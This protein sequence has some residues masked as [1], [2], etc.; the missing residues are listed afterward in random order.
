MNAICLVIDRLH[1]GY[2]GA[3]GN[4]WI[5]T[6]AVDR[7]ASQS[8]L[9]DQA[10]L[11]SPDLNKIYRSYWQ[12]CHALCAQGS[13]GERPSL[14]ACLR[15]SGVST[16]L[17]TD[18]PLVARHALAADFDS[19]VEIDPPWQSRVA[20][21]IE[22]THF[23]G[24]FLQIIDYLQSARE[25][26]MLW[27]HLAGLGST[28]DAPLS[29]RQAYQDG[30]DP[31]P[32]HRAEVPERIL[33]KNYDPDEL[34]G[35]TQCY[36]GQVSLLDTCLEAFLDFL[37][38][39]TVRE[40]LLLAVTSSRGFPLGEHG[41]I[42]PCDEALY[43]ELVQVP[44]LLRFPDGLG[45]AARSQTLV[46]P[47]DLWAT[48][49]QW[50]QIKAAQ[51]SPTA[52]SLIPVVREDVAAVRDRM[53]L[54]GN[55]GERAMRTPAW[56]LRTMGEAELYAKPDDRWEVNN[57]QS[58]CLDVVENLQDALVRYE[59]AIQSGSIVDLPPLSEVLIH[60][61]D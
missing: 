20:K 15:E 59:Q 53:C 36:A 39:L 41:R 8:F 12:G 30:G 33:A 34:L 18:E 44:L 31:N 37:D 7:L 56:Y 4:T 58:R 55:G 24:C 13:A 61:L 60:G 17:V 11:D 57:V 21:E 22:Q 3:Y 51:G 47:A 35:I 49:S 42:G 45:A 10:L 25:P 6:P 46:E 9:F 48:L 50:W 14:A 16:A 40:E 19:I 43:G 28:W 26:F 29:F 52:A 32:P 27:C 1:A 2:L 5:E 54:A 23:A 38:D